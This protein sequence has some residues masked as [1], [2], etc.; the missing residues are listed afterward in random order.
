VYHSNKQKFNLYLVAMSV[1]TFSAII[2]VESATL[3]ELAF[4][5]RFSPGVVNGTLTELSD[6]SVE[7]FTFMISV[8]N[9]KHF[10]F[11]I[12]TEGGVATQPY[13]FLI[14]EQ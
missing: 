2:C 8:I 7:N 6:S 5:A 9:G 1:S 12:A 4:G 11:G 10:I 3:V 13:N 14:M